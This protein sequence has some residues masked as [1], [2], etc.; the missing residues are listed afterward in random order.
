MNIPEP[1]PWLVGPMDDQLASVDL[2]CIPHAGGGASTFHP[3]RAQL[4]SEVALYAVQLP[5]R[6]QRY[7]E[8]PVLSL[9]DIVGPLSRVI[10]NRGARPLV[11]FGH[12]MG[13]VVALELA[14]RLHADGL[15]GPASLVVS[16]RQAPHL[17]SRA[18]AIAHLSPRDVVRVI[19]ERHG[20]IPAAVLAEP[21]LVHIMGRALRADLSIVERYLVPHGEPLEIPL[22]AVGGQ[23]D[24]SV[25]RDE[26]E[27]WR[28]YTTAPFRCVQFPGDHFYF[29]THSGQLPLLEMIRDACADARNRGSDRS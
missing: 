8:E 6:E 21:E 11:V 27:A 5:G 9:N 19:A 1:S 22:I 23:D 12:S 16:S 29:R 10:A 20:G 18:P 3:W 7:H 24:S 26:L 15:P 17:A 2:I 28:V 25:N 4:G 13:A 14:R